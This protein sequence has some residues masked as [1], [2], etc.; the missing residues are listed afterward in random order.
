MFELSLAGLLNCSFVF[1]FG[2]IGAANILGQ[3]HAASL[4]SSWED[5]PGDTRVVG[6]FLIVAASLLA[7]EAARFWGLALGEISLFCAI[8]MLLYKSKYV[9]ALAGIPLLTLLPI[10]LVV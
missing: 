2:V 10:V 7:I 4:F 9:H 6:A 1:L 5:E 3:K 8:T